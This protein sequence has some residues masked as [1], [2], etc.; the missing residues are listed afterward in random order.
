MPLRKRICHKLFTYVHEAGLKLHFK[1]HKEQKII[2]RIFS[3][4]ADPR[5]IYFTASDI[6]NFPKTSIKLEV[7]EW[8]R[9]R[10][11]PSIAK[12]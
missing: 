12:Y 4:A 3:S 1:Y 6:S 2:S 8:S 11:T 10:F 5:I 7:N 9:K